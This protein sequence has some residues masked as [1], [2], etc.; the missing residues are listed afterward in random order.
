MASVDLGDPMF[1]F[2]SPEYPSS[3]H[4]SLPAP[5]P[6]WPCPPCRITTDIKCG[7]P[8]GAVLAL[9]CGEIELS[10]G[11]VC[12]FTLACSTHTCTHPCHTD[13]CDPC[14]V[15]ETAHCWCSKHEKEFGCGEGEAVS[16]SSFS[17]SSPEAEEL[18]I[19]RFACADSCDRLFA[20]GVHCCAQPCHTGRLLAVCG[21]YARAGVDDPLARLNVHLNTCGADS[22]PL[23]SMPVLG[24]TS[25]TP[26][27]LVDVPC[28]TC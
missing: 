27:L 10:C 22:P 21:V 16:C 25:P 26:A 6:P 12:G 24:L 19:G 1:G 17:P 15:H 5:L 28:P 4:T 2:P 18:W 11:T 23:V 7:C 20:C 13:T 8:K 14:A 9:R 3:V